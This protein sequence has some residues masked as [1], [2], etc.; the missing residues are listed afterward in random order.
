MPYRLCPQCQKPGRLLESSSSI[1]NV[2]YFR[3]D[4][5]G[6]VW[7]H[8]KDNPN[9]PPKDITTPKHEQT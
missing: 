1:A 7:T 9:A 2:L 3:C 4:D 6:H 8:D 5:C